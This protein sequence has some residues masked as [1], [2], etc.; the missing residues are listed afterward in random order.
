MQVGIQLPEVERVVPWDE[1]R[2]MAETA[3]EVGFASLWLGDHF[4]Y[5]R[6]DEDL[7]PWECWSMLAA[8]AAVTDRVLLG[9]LVSPTGFRNP[10]VLAKMAATVD[11]ISG[12]RLV[13][14]LGSGWNEREFD[15]YGV[16]Y[17]R[18][19]SR[20]EEE[21]RIIT[22][23]IRTGRSTF[24]G[25]FFSQDDNVLI[26][27]ARNDLPIMIGST[28]PRMLS[29]TA[30][31]MDWWNEWFANFGNQPDKLAKLIDQLDVSLTE[32]GRAPGDI[33][34]SAALYVH[35]GGDERTIPKRITPIS[36]N[37]AEITEQLMAFAGLVDHVQLVVDPITIE[38]IEALA[39]VVQAIHGI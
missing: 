18:R 31:E 2:R 4:L 11:E 37:A 30:G 16:P 5:R 35:L 24:A 27:P 8:L 23:L 21:F 39:P 13:L 26:P 20:F 15:A 6:K 1:Y 22:D 36:G 32:A 34:R 17:D 7:G 10:A 33:V 3:E 12:G 25:E 9:P 19:V 38:S 28:G 14:G 29:I